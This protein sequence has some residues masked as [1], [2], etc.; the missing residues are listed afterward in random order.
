MDMFQ[1]RFANRT[2]PYKKYYF[3][4]IKSLMEDQQ[5]NAQFI[6]V[7]KSPTLDQEVLALFNALVELKPPKIVERYGNLSIILIRYF[8]ELIAENLSRHHEERRINN[9]P[10]RLLELSRVN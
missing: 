8:L 6:A 2:P 1:E 5:L 9:L 10:L 4:L 3:E 7:A